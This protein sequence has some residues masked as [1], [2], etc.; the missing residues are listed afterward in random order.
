VIFDKPIIPKNISRRIKQ[1]LYAKEHSF[2][3]VVQPGFEIIA[4]KEFMKIVPSMSVS[5][6]VRGGIEFS[7]SVDDIRNLNLLSRTATRFMMRVDSFRAIY[8]ERF[9]ERLSRIPWEIYISP[10]VKVSFSISCSESRLYHTGRL[11]EEAVSALST[12]MNQTYPG[13]DGIAMTAD[14]KASSQVILIRL[15]KDDCT[16]SIDTTGEPLYKRGYRTFVEKAPIRETFAASILLTAGMSDY[17]VLLDPMCGS[18]VFSLE[19]ALMKKGEPAGI[20]R[21]FA[22]EKWPGFSA[23]SFEYLKKTLSGD[24]AVRVPGPEIFASDIDEKAVVTAGKNF[25]ESGVS[26]MINLSV[27][28]FFTIARS[29]FE[30]KKVL[31]VLNPPYGKRIVPDE[32]L[33]FYKRIIL[34]VANLKPECC[35]YILVP[36]KILKNTGISQSNV[37]LQCNNGGIALALIRI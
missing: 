15:D 10:S 23:A 16:V 12:S 5:S 14:E 18:G 35:A 28:D 11:E 36:S 4:E 31:V 9:R 20:R 7:C 3:A 13:W 29:G 32:I 37:V 33:P 24:S 34:Q 25:D 8:F 19:A 21:K 6:R 27:K 2:F 1:N 22:F 26:D 17:D 30:R